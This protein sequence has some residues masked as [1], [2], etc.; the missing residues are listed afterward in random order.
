M[1]ETSGNPA[2][3]AQLTGE[4]TALGRGEGSLGKCSSMERYVAVARAAMVSMV[5]RGYDLCLGMYV[6]RVKGDEISS[7]HPRSPDN[8]IITTFVTYKQ[9]SSCVLLMLCDKRHE[10][11]MNSCI[12]SF[13]RCAESV[14]QREDCL[15]NVVQMRDLACETQT[16]RHAMHPPRIL[17]SPFP[18]QAQSTTRYSSSLVQ[19]PVATVLEPSLTVNLCPCSNANG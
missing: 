14:P 2:N 18:I 12:P 8:V 16:K 10:E 13:I 3:T 19:S 17:T 1:R 6:Y 7:I 11:G 9:F 15:Q 5:L 4:T